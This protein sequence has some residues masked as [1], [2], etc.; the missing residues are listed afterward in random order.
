VVYA[1]QEVSK[2][3]SKGAKNDSFC[4]GNERCEVESTNAHAHCEWTNIVGTIKESTGYRDD[5]HLLHNGDYLKVGQTANLQ[6]RRDDFVSRALEINGYVGIA[7]ENTFSPSCFHQIG[8][9]HGIDD[10]AW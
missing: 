7:G 3:A 8:E 4:P 9:R 5:F 6:N 2:T 10:Q 1:V